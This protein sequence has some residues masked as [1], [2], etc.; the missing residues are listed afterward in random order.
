[1]SE[2]FIKTNDGR[3]IGSD[4]LSHNMKQPKGGFLKQK[5]DE[6]KEVDTTDSSVL[7]EDVDIK[8]KPMR[9]NENK[10]PKRLQ[11]V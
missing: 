6:E 2:I 9:L 7:E 8:T 10:D 11:L 4:G 3:Y 1:M 5:L